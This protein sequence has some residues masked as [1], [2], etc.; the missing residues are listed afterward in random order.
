MSIV[1]LEGPLT[2]FKDRIS[3][4]R[5]IIVAIESSSREKDLLT[6]TRQ[7]VDLNSIGA[8]SSNTVNAMS[9]VFL[10]SSFEEFVREEIKECATLLE[11]KYVNLSQEDK[12]K[13][14]NYY[15]STNLSRI[16]FIKSI[17]TKDKPRSPDTTTVGKLR[18]LIDCA[19]N[20]VLDDNPINLDKANFYHHNNNFKA[21]VVDELAQRIAA[22]SLIESGGESQKIKNYFGTSTKKDTAEKLRQK[23]ND[24]Y[25]IRNT[26]VHSLSSASGY[27]V[28][29]VFDYLNFFEIFSESIK[30]SL[31]KHISTW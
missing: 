12:H 28:D 26:L 22:P 19:R 25:D 21:H 5:R 9:L 31:N 23:L 10:A 24:F 7:N 27:A 20:F 16:S 1:D 2:D 4:I 3:E 15:W 8:T 13:I 6:T 29:A 11:I 14:R 17:L 18:Q 30:S